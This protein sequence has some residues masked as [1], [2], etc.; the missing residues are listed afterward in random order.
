VSGADAPADGSRFRHLERR[1][2]AAG[3]VPGRGERV[4]LTTSHPTADP[5]TALERLLLPALSRTPCVVGFSGGRDSSLI[6]AT[7]LRLARREGL[8]EPVA[9]TK[10]YPGHAE[11]DETAWQEY[12]VRHLGVTDWE[13]Q[14]FDDE[15]D[16]LGPAAKDSLRRHGALWPATVHT[17]APQLEVARGGAYLGGEGGDE[18]LGGFRG[19]AWSALRSGALPPG[20]WAAKELVKAFAPRH[21]RRY[22]ARRRRSED[23]A[24]DW[25]RPELRAWFQRTLVEDEVRR[26]LDHAA[27]LGDHL[28]RRAL[29][30]AMH[31]LHGIGRSLDVD[32]VQPLVAPSF[33]AAL[34]RHAPRLGPADRTATMRAHFAD[35]LP[36]ALLARGH[37]ATFNSAYAGR[38]TRAFVASWDGSGLDLELIDP[39]A[40]RRVWSEP[41]LHGGTFQ[42]VQAAWLAGDG[43]ADPPTSGPGRPLTSAREEQP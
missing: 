9:V 32:Y 33:A 20:R 23:S 41:V 21:L 42:L 11:A 38:H 18:V 34:A 13:V 6:L 8:P 7:A 30:V 2:F 28:S 22:V 40:L 19:A 43:A 39:D 15:F 4:E 14:T 12:V 29:Q 37:K 17:R 3:W 35:L 24:R 25:L 26:P 1:E 31:N 36:D 27:A 10:R 16:L 5:I